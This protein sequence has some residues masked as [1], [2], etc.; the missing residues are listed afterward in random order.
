M[1]NT[2]RRPTGLPS[3]AVYSRLL[4]SKYRLLESYM[5]EAVLQGGR[6]RLRHMVMDERRQA[7]AGRDRPRRAATGY[8]ALQQAMAGY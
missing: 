6:G 3:R 8:G 1:R 2:V 7:V 4:T 5:A